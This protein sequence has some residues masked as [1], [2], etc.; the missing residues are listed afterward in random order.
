MKNNTNIEEELNEIDQM[1]DTLNMCRMDYYKLYE[2]DFK[3]ASIRLRKRLEYIIQTSKQMKRDA[4]KHRKEI[5][6]KQEN[7]K[8]EARNAGYYD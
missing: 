2:K 4:L 1:I 3:V 5:E 7:A 8:N 6:Q